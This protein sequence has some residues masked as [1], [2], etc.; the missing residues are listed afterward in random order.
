LLKVSRKSRWEL[1][2]GIVRLPSG[3]SSFDAAGIDKFRETI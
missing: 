3:E 1:R 2:Y